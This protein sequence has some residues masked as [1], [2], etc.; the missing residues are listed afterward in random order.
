ML[1]RSHYVAC[2]PNEDGT[3]DFYDT[4]YEQGKQTMQFEEFMESL[5]E[6]DLLGMAALAISKGENQ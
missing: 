5:G 4:E 2:R 6:E 3:F 1:F